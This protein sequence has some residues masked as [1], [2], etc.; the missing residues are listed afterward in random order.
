MRGIV[1]K[2]LLFALIVLCGCSDD[3]EREILSD[4]SNELS[5]VSSLF[6]LDSEFGGGTRSMRGNF[7]V[8][9]Q[10]WPL[11]SS[12]SSSR[13]TPT[14]SLHGSAG[15]LGYLHSG[16]WGTSVIPYSDLNNIEF[17]FS[18]DQLT[19]N[20]TP[21]YWSDISDF[22]K[23]SL[24][25]YAYSPKSLGNTPEGGVSPLGVAA[26]GVPTISYIV[27]QNVLQQHDLITATS[28][29]VDKDYRTP[30][31]LPFTHALTAIR[32]KVGFDCTIKSVSVNNVYNKGT[33]TFGEDWVVDKLSKDSYT[34]PGDSLT[35]N[36][37]TLMLLPQ[38]LP[39]GSEVVLVYNDGD[40]ADKTIRAD[41]SSLE[42][43]PGKLITY[44]L[45]AAE[46][47]DYI[48][49]DLAAGN[50][51]IS[52][53]TYKGYIYVGGSSTPQLVQGVHSKDNRY[54]VYQSSRNHDSVSYKSTGW[55]VAVNDGVC[56]LP[57]YHPVTYNN[58]LWSDYIT[59]NT[60]VE[61]VILAWSSAVKSAGRD[62]TLNTIRV[63]GT[64]DCNL[65]IDNLFSK[66]QTKSN[67]RTTGGI[68][69]IPTRL[70][71][72]SSTLNIT[73]IG[74]NRFGNIYYSN[75]SNNGSKIVFGGTGSITVADVDYVINTT[76]G[77]R[78]ANGYYS[79]HWAS[80]IG[81][82]D[83]T[84]TQDAYGIHINSGVIW[85]GST[86]AENCTAIGGGG[87][88]HTTI[89]ISGGVVTAVA[90]TTGTAIG[91][92]IG[93]Q[94]TGGIGN[95]DIS[96]GN[97]Y[98]YNFANTW[99][100]P[101][102]AIGGA[103]SNLGAG[104][105]GYVNISGGNVYALAALGTAIG[106]GSSKTNRGGDA[107][108]VISGGNVIA[109]S[110][111]A[112]G[113]A[114]GGKVGQLLP[115]G[116]GIG[117]GTGGSNAGVNG[118]TAQVTITGNPIIRT[119]SI[120][121]GKTNN[122]TGKIGS[123]NI[124]ISGGDIQ[125]QFV[126]AK[127]SSVA[128]YFEMTGGWIRN[129][130]TNDE[131]YYHVQDNGGAVYM[132]FGKCQIKGGVIDNCYGVK[133]GAIYINGDTTT[134]FFVM[135]NGIIRNCIA[136][137]DGGAICLEGGEVEISGGTIT[138]NMANGGNGG[139]ISIIDGNFDMSNTALITRNSSLYNTTTGLGGNGGG[140][141]IT[142]TDSKVR[143]NMTAGSITENSSDRTGGGVCVDM[144]GNDNS[145]TVTVGG[146]VS[147]T[148]TINPTISNNN[149]ILSG[150][151]LYV[152]GANANVVINSGKIYYNSTAA[153][154]DNEDV[155][156]ELGMVKLSG[157]KLQHAVVTFHGNGGFYTKDD[158]D[159]YTAVQN[160]VTA[161]NSTLVPPESFIQLGYKFTGWNT[162]ADGNGEPYTNGQIMNISND[163]ELYAQ[164]EIL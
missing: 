148:D 160:I 66:F 19:S 34:I 139:G 89:K 162:R 58:E 145:A 13:V 113:G 108:V 37:H 90:T 71:V 56:L 147:L 85:A 48:Y 106:G 87:N 16:T 68:A 100:I 151:G 101:S 80:V 111:T 159:Y 79:N 49:F 125:A 99:D 122:S 67:S 9:V 116:A 109:K 97:V 153:F 123:A 51:E 74:D 88:G 35:K 75:P 40:V 93:F 23:D 154:V 27:P 28:F 132:D 15:M 55:S 7:T 137:G 131:E 39:E 12:Q 144:T 69:F 33:Y 46:D 8:D 78:G 129:S 95:I 36:S 105:K 81:A 4:N 10:N 50:V 128:P 83:G 5:F 65:V 150:G 110:I 136:A 158:V 3:F 53:S 70:S 84:S 38:D 135:N 63:T 44:T 45:Y 2:I 107:E 86:A 146:V 112:I 29:S 121:G 104:S 21:V 98:A 103:G 73:A 114:K 120:G 157:G 119:G 127:G 134:T 54:Y 92:G 82:D 14:F 64:L 76:D 141:Y 102:A 18:G 155:A 72:D 115:A 41:I 62:S 59:N 164:W 57:N 32:F 91:G 117:G 20:D 1:S 26:N 47:S 130:Y 52:P 30:I 124:E 142:S 126:M 31:S 156:N 143:V 60:E 42:W 96:G 152:S 133:G 163:L 25:V 77:N 149:T 140:V 161:T 11:Y 6:S 61:K 43:E 22:G 24:R 94:G 17:F 118:G 138:D